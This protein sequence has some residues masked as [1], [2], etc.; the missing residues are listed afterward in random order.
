MKSW[1]ADRLLFPYFSEK[2]M[3][4]W[5]MLDHSLASKEVFK[6]SCIKPETNNQKKMLHKIS[7]VIFSRKN[8]QKEAIPF[9]SQSSPD[10]TTWKFLS[11]EE[12]AKTQKL[13]TSPVGFVSVPI[14]FPRNLFRSCSNRQQH[15]IH[16]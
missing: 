14:Y 13:N 10:P 1:V 12:K 4:L 15:K 6:W 9:P 2:K 16:K 8:T 3:G 11:N 7:T 5:S